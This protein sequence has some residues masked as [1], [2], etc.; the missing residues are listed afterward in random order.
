MH[1]NARSIPEELIWPAIQFGQI[2]QLN[3]VFV[4]MSSAL[5]AEGRVP[6]SKD[7]DLQITSQCW[8]KSRSHLPIGK[9]NVDMPSQ[10]LQICNWGYCA[11][12]ERLG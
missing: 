6:G 5:S 1:D 9:R 11:V 4:I 7:V 3:T 12:S 2:S 10:Q 8:L